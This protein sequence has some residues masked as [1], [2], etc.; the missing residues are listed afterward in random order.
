MPTTLWSTNGFLAGIRF[1]K[2][3]VRLTKKGL[4]GGVGERRRRKAE[5]LLLLEG[6]DET[7]WLS[8][9]KSLKRICT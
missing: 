2:L 3:N 1:S 4:G 5:L 9:G 7:S 6:Q 8:L